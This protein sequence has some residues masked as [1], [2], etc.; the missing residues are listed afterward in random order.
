MGEKSKTCERFGLPPHPVT[1]AN[2]GLGWDSPQQVFHI[3]LVVT[4]ACR[5]GG[6][7]KI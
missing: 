5:M 7:P 6:E 1:V 3:I 4:I 2:E